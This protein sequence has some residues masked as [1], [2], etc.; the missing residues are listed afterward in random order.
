MWLEHRALWKVFAT[1]GQ[2]LE[3][4]AWFQSQLVSSHW[5]LRIPEGMTNALHEWSDP[6]EAGGNL[7]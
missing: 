2:Y 7:K 4:M 3:D 6:R 1:R 5:P